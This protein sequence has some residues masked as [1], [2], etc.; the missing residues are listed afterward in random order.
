MQET[1]IET[2]CGDTRTLSQHPVFKFD[3]PPIHPTFIRK[4]E[5]AGRNHLPCPYGRM[6]SSQ[7][8]GTE[9]RHRTLVMDIRLLWYE[10]SATHHRRSHQCHT[11]R[12]GAGR[13]PARLR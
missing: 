9:I 4:R 6:G 1:I 13:C 3:I 11:S 7:V 12:D 5:C 8:C 10:T 2:E